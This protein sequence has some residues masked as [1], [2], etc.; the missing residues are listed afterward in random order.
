VRRED[1]VHLAERMVEL[2]G[3]IT[4]H[5]AALAAALLSR[6][7]P[8]GNG[9]PDPEG[10]L[11]MLALLARAGHEDDAEAA[12]AWTQGAAKLEAGGFKL[13]S[14]LPAYA[15]VNAAA[16]AD[17]TS[18]AARLAAMKERHRQL[19]IEAMADVA[20]HDGLIRPAELEVLRTAATALGCP[21]PPL[22]A[23]RADSS[24]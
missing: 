22:D 15:T 6:L 8:E 23:Q 2:D 1:L 14:P 4:P 20:A 18:H 16:N 12:A 5:E 10:A 7:S 9:K 11:A 21:M 19:L 17:A 13:P 24:R 3:L